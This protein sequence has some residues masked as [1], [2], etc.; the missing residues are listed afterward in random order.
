MRLGR[1]HN[2]WVVGSSPTRP[3]GLALFRL[4]CNRYKLSFWWLSQRSAS[5]A[6]E[7]PVPAAVIA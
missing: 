2:P 6:A 5:S 1:P 3:T 4:K 7:H